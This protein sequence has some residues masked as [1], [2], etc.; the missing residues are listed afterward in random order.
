MPRGFSPNSVPLGQVISGGQFDWQ[1]SQIHRRNGMAAITVGCDPHDGTA[2]NELFG[3]LRKEIEAI[4]VPPGYTM[5]WG[6]QYEKSIEAE[7]MLLGKLPVTLVFI[8]VIV[9]ALF[10]S[11]R[12]PMIT[13]LTFPL[14]LIGITIGLLVTGFSFGFM[15]LV[16][17]MSL[18]GMTVRNGVVLMSRIDVELAQGESPYEAVVTAS[19]ERMRPVTVA[20]MTVVVGM[21]P[22]LRDP[23]FNSMAA[24]IMFGL[25]F[26]TGLTLFIVPVLYT[27]FFRI[28]P[29]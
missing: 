13:L 29:L 12:Q 16:G 20:A 19:V 23:L 9:V 27:L 6:G 21:I 17:A 3:T 24:S 26:A 10:N 4:P 15:A 2:W 7:T 25:V 28:K 18:L 8:G 14:M 5:E 1:P 11:I 22:L